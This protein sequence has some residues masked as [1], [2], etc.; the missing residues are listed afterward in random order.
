MGLAEYTAE[1]NRLS[2]KYEKKCEWKQ[3]WSRL[4]G[5]EIGLPKKSKERGSRYVE[6]R[7]N[8]LCKCRE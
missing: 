3:E 6:S 4:N 7:E 2:R 1:M 5:N 8:K